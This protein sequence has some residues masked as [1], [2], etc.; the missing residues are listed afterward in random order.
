M[1][2]VRPASRRVSIRLSCSFWRSSVFSPHP[3]A[4]ELLPSP[5]RLVHFFSSV[6]RTVI[7]CS[8]IA[9]RRSANVNVGTG[10]RSWNCF[11][12]SGKRNAVRAQKVHQALS[13]NTIRIQRYVHCVAM[14]EAPTIVNRPLTKHSDRQWLLECVGKESLH[15][16]G[17]IQAPPHC[18]IVAN[19]R[20][21]AN[22]PALG[23]PGAFCHLFLGL[24]FTQRFSNL[25]ICVADLPARFRN[26][27]SLG[28]N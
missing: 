17:I 24:R 21:G 4:I 8:L 28:S 14:I 25:R 13:F 1:Q 22:E 20:S 27:V 7:S 18:A 12:K 3:E 11:P 6:A 9:M 15:F 2:N 10:R 23:Q 26:L 19:E 5:T 16:P